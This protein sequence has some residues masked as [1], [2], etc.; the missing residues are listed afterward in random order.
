MT[1]SEHLRTGLKLDL[2]PGGLLGLPY[3]CLHDLEVADD[4]VLGGGDGGGAGETVPGRPQLAPLHHHNTQV[5]Q[6]L[7]QLQL[8][9]VIIF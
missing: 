7:H 6:T 9:N 4:V 3:L 2:R 1:D 5:V 8:N